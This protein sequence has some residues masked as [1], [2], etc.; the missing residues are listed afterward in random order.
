MASHSLAR[1]MYGTSEDHYLPR[2]T[3]SA[4]PLSSTSAS[5]TV[6]EQTEKTDTL[7]ALLRRA[8]N[9]LSGKH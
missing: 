2:A 3:T 1:I 8:W 7:G 9:N 6:N 5:E 4:V